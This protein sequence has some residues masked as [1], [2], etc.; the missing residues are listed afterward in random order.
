[1]QQ[2]HKEHESMHNQEKEEDC[3]IGGYLYCS[4]SMVA[5]GFFAVTMLG[6]LL[7][8]IEPQACHKPYSPRLAEIILA[9]A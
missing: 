1:M 5:K 3:T 4:M 8:I 6:W 2:G 7:L 9:A